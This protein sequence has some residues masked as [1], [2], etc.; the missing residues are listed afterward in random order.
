[1]EIQNNQCSSGF[2]M[3]ETERNHFIVCPWSE[4]A[5]MFKKVVQDIT[6]MRDGKAAHIENKICPKHIND[7]D[8]KGQ[9]IPHIIQSATDIREK[10]R[11]RI[12]D[13]CSKNQV[14]I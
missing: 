9:A 11:Q 12:I 4:V 8:D 2:N 13:M 10:Q 1:M 5:D 14:F 3:L 7:M 6:S